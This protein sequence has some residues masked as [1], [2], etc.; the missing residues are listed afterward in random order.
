MYPYSLPAAAR[1]ICVVQ[2]LGCKPENLPANRGPSCRAAK[3]SAPRVFACQAGR[4][5]D[6]PQVSSWGRCCPAGYCYL[7]GAC[8]LCSAAMRARSG[9]GVSREGS[10][11]PRRLQITDQNS[12]YSEWSVFHAAGGYGCLCGLRLS[13]RDWLV[14]VLS[15]ASKSLSAWAAQVSLITFARCAKLKQLNRTYVKADRYI[16]DNFYNFFS[17]RRRSWP[18]QHRQRYLSQR[19]NVMLASAVWRAEPLP[20]SYRKKCPCRAAVVRL[21]PRT[22]LGKRTLVSRCRARHQRSES[23]VK[24]YA[25]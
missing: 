18:T 16:L 8:S 25:R 13:V 5:S 4:R 20:T 23:Q 11:R 12:Q 15:A 2:D 19:Q 10:R 1:V 24:S 21:V 3:D 17:Q 9:L 6:V 22:P 7:R 14:A